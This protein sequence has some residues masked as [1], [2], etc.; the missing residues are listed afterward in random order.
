MG[1]LLGT[2]PARP[3]PTDVSASQPGSRYWTYVDG[4]EPHSPGPGISAFAIDTPRAGDRLPGDGLE[5]NGWVIA[6]TA[7]VRGIRT[8]GADTAG[9]IFPL[10]RQRPDV[11]ADYADVPHAAASGFSFWTP[12]YAQPSYWH[13]EVEAVLDDG[14]SRPLCAI[15]GHSRTEQ[16][17]PSPSARL[18]TAPDFAIIGTQRGGTT[19]LHAYLRAHPRVEVPATKELHYV[20]DRFSRGRDWY[21]GQFPAELPPGVITGEATP[22]ALFHPASPARLHEI[23]PDAKLIVLLRNPVD[24]AYSHFLL[25][26]SRGH[27]TLPFEIA[28]DAE[29][30]RLTGEEVRLLADPTYVSANH[31]QASYLSRGDYAPQLERW[32][33]LYPRQQ[34]LILRSE[35]LYQHTEEVF[36]QVT[37]FLG[38]PP[39]R[40]IPFATHNPTSGPPLSAMTRARLEKHFAP[41]NAN[42]ANLLGW[43]ETW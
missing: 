29:T 35:D 16:Y 26:T 18:V 13:L 32:L 36:H 15:Y 33:E 14:S 4:L 40:D 17:S 11:A 37:S 24:R 10:N 38:L 28:V 34:M 22:Y 25:E 19:S 6:R 3:C 5:I 12:I 43:T 42:L 23:A 1:H 2:S 7:P 41:L 31:N 8:A 39:A 30:S 21:L 20:T 27:E 9:A